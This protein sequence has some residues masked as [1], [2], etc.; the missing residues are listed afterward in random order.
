MFGWHIFNVILFLFFVGLTGYFGYR[1]F[2]AIATAKSLFD[3]LRASIISSITEIGLITIQFFTLTGI[4]LWPVLIIGVAYTL[5]SL[6]IDFILSAF[7]GLGSTST[8]RKSFIL[9]KY[10]T[11]TQRLGCFASVTSILI[12]LIMAVSYFFAIRLSWQDAGNA[13]LVSF[14][15]FSVPVFFGVVFLQSV[16]LVSMISRYI[17]QEVRFASIGPSVGRALI[18]SAMAAVPFLLFSDDLQGSLNTLPPIEVALAL[19]F[20]LFAV[21]TTLVLFLGGQRYRSERAE[22]NTALLTAVG[23]I[24]KALNMS[25]EAMREETIEKEIQALQSATAPIFMNASVFYTVYIYH[26]TE[27]KFDLLPEGQFD[28]ILSQ[29]FL[30][31]EI[32]ANTLMELVHYDGTN[33]HINAWKSILENDGHQLPKWDFVADHIKKT[34]D[35]YCAVTVQQD[36]LEDVLNYIAEEGDTMPPSTTQKTVQYGIFVSIITGLTSLYAEEIKLALNKLIGL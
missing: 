31:F 32:G 7:F 29:T 16:G 5:L 17:D 4:F 28:E 8:T 27:E 12:L 21:T 26:L 1:N 36:R 10:I 24:R 9:S 14:Y 20:G 22:L 11:G 30:D 13:A 3:R 15:V 33:E 6:L 23:N 35:L 19:P 34:H 25:S 18:A 2:D